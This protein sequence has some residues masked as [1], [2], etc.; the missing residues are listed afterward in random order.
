MSKSTFSADET[1]KIAGLI[2]R[3]WS[4]PQLKEQYERAPAAVLAGAD[5]ELGDREAPA[6]PSPPE[7]VVDTQRGTEMAAGFSSAS[8]AS[9]VS[10][11]CTAFTASCANCAA[12]AMRVTDPAQTETLMKLIEDP[13]GRA[14]A[15]R[16]MSAWNVRIAIGPE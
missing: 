6:I 5:V 1:M 13:Q 10:C 11:P 8:S 16:M 9:T 12:E 14:D 15:R 7:L 4:D 3:V 2:A